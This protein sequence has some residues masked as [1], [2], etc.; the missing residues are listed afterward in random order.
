[1]YYISNGVHSPMLAHQPPQQIKNIMKLLPPGI[2]DSSRDMEILKGNLLDEVN[3]DY[4]FSLRKSIG[5]RRICYMTAMFLTCTAILL[6]CINT[7]LV[8]SVLIM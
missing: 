3:K 5:S 2:Q 7:L 8:M 1:M 4:G 6:S